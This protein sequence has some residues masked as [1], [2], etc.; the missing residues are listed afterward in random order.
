V[1]QKS[2][3]LVV[4][5]YNV[6]ENFPK[7]ELYGLVSQIRRAAVA[8]PSN[9]AEGYIRSQIEWFMKQRKKILPPNYSNESFYRDLGILEKKP[10]AK[11]PIVEV[12]RKLKSDKNN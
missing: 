10:E 2:K 6:T 1:W 8:I 3:D 9:I 12:L 5:I 11:N 4:R 7:A